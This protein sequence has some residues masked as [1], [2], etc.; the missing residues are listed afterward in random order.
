MPIEC[1]YRWCKYH[2]VHDPDPRFNEGPFCY[3]E[4]CHATKED[5]LI[6]SQKRKE[7]LKD[8]TV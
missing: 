4:D 3:E 6:F 2:G 5:I 1:Y 8:D 7:E